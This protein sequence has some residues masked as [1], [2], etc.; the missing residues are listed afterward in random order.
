MTR[1]RAGGLSVSV[2]PIHLRFVSSKCLFLE[3]A[4]LG[5]SGPGPHGPPW[6]PDGTGANGPPVPG[7]NGPTQMQIADVVEHNIHSSCLL[8]SLFSCLLWSTLM[9]QTLMGRALM[10]PALMGPSGP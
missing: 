7:P 5:P 8:N 10:S 1:T 2:E 4:P 3:L 9:S 6:G